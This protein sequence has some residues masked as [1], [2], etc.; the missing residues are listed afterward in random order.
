[1]T[2]S[3]PSSATAT[4]A[5]VRPPRRGPLGLLRRAAGAVRWSFVNDRFHVFVRT[6]TDDHASFEAPEGYRFDWG[7]A[8]DVLACEEFHTELGLADREAGAARL[9]LDHRVVIGFDLESGRAVFSMWV[10]PRNLNIPGAIKRAL[11][12]DQVFIYKAFTSPEHRGRKLYQAGMRFVLHDLRQRGGREVVGYAHLA[13]RASRGGL[14]A[15]GFDSVGGFATRGFRRWQRSF[16]DAD[17]TARFPRTV[18]RTG[19][20]LEG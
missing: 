9:E 8:E 19:L 6:V 5:E 18:A 15:L 12:A 14:G 1:M 4:T 13:K 7:T 3:Q 20:G 17:L 2:N 11:A 16:P 10:N